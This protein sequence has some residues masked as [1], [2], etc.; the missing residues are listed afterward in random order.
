MTWMNW[1]YNLKTARKLALGFGL[2]LALTLLVGAVAISRMAQMN[3]KAGLLDAG[4]SRGMRA[5]V[6]FSG[7]MRQFR[8]TEYRAA[9]NND[10]AKFAKDAA[11][12]AEMRDQAREGLAAYEA[13]V[14][15]PEDRANIEALKASWAQ[16]LALH[17]RELMPALRR[18]DSAREKALL[19]DTM[20]D[21]SLHMYDQLDAML[22]WNERRS[23]RLRAEADQAYVSERS[24]VLSLLALAVLLGTL[25][26]VVTTR[27]MTSTLAQLSERMK[28]LDAICV[29]NL[30]RA[31]EALERGDLTAEIATGTEPLPT[32]I[33]DEFGDVARTFNTILA[34][35]KTT[36]ASFRQ[37]QAGLSALVLQM[38]ASAA[39]VSGAADALAG[40]SQQIGATTEGIGASMQEVAQASE[41]S[42]KG[43]GEIA[44]G[45]ASQAASIAEGAEQVRG[46]VAAVQSVT[47]DAEAAT[48]ATAQATEAATAGT[49]AVEQ[50]VAGMGRIQQSVT[51]AAQVIHSLGATSAQIGGIVQTIDEIAGQTN[52]LALNAASGEMNAAAQEVSQTISEVAAVVEESSAAAEEMSAS[53]EQVSASVRTVAGTTAQQGAAVDELVA[54]ADALSGVSQALSGLVARFRASGASEYDAAEDAASGGPAVLTLRRVA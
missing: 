51:Q 11:R 23:A 37:S 49:Q 7:P 20:R 34:R 25:I 4:T 22:G 13:G 21:I 33:G 53:A 1:F 50:T 36:I 14:S 45:S 31:V 19:N 18:A 30:T 52:L 47:R 38:Q 27:Y 2:C 5:L 41:Q 28:M 8:I 43:A 3:R 29:T 35:V 40:T 42:A 10:P 26:A 46:L 32:N 6:T 15:V 44:Q 48:R 16:Y 17:D 24:A 9:L 39:Q 12:L 54:S